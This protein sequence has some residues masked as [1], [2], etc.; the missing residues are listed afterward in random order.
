V[1]EVNLFHILSEQNH[2]IGIEFTIFFNPWREIQTYGQD[3]V[4]EGHRGAQ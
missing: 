3:I 2:L 1:N 4:G